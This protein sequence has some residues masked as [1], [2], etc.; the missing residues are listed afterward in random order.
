MHWRRMTVRCMWNCVIIS[1]QNFTWH[2]HIFNISPCLKNFQDTSITMFHNKYKISEGIR[3]NWN[4]IS[5]FFSFFHKRWKLWKIPNLQMPQPPISYSGSLTTRVNRITIGLAKDESPEI[6]FLPGT[7]LSLQFEQHQSPSGRECIP[8]Q[9]A[10][11][12]K[13]KTNKC[14]IKTITQL[15][16]LNKLLLDWP[17]DQRVWSIN[18]TKEW[19]FL[20]TPSGDQIIKKFT[21]V[22]IKSKLYI[23]M[24]VQLPQ[25]SLDIW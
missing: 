15:T 9:A 17:R 2:R 12:F 18:E 20:F 24:K 11:H 1:D 8:K 10:K 21:S 16:F 22:I 23:I 14:Q 4:K 6:I 3:Q 13:F 7:K 19:H 25:L 5:F